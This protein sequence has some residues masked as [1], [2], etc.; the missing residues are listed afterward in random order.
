LCIFK[1]CIRAAYRLVDGGYVVRYL[2]NKYTIELLP[3]HIQG[4]GMASCAKSVSLHAV[5]T[6]NLE[7]RA[8][9]KRNTI[10]YALPPRTCSR[11][12]NLG[13]CRGSTPKYRGKQSVGHSSRLRHITRVSDTREPIRSPSHIKGLHK[14]TMLLLRV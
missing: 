1:A 11:M 6:P 7:L 9:C 13:R 12:C 4:T 8:S 5:V 14:P 2:Y 3:D 10:T